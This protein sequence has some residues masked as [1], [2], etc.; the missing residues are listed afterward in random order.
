MESTPLPYRL[1]IDTMACPS[2]PPP[3]LVSPW[4]PRW[5][6]TSTPDGRDGSAD[7]RSVL[8]PRLEQ[9]NWPDSVSD[10]QLSDFTVWW[11]DRQ[12]SFSRTHPSNPG[13]LAMVR[14]SYLAFAGEGP[15]P[16]VL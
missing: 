7:F 13:R 8:P 3:P 2:P 11:A 1:H 10:Y 16:S 9:M 4:L 6:P 12:L 14:V 5:L 15:S